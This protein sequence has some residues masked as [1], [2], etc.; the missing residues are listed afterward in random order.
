MAKPSVTTGEKRGLIILLT[1][2][3]VIVLYLALR[4]NARQQP[5]A[6]PLVNTGT[7]ADTLATVCP[8]ESIDSLV[9]GK[10]TLHGPKVKS[11]SGK[12]PQ[13]KGIPKRS[14]RDQK[15]N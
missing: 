15:I 13:R 5:S 14:P 10:V 2:L 11:K 9:T 6:T 3:A 4:H 12:N 8:H 7:A 1:L